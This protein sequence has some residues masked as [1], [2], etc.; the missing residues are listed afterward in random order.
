[1]V[2]LLKC[3]PIQQANTVITINTVIGGVTFEVSNRYIEKKS[4]SK[5]STRIVSE[6]TLEE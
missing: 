3:F 5:F 2:Y 4:S 1:M 6:T